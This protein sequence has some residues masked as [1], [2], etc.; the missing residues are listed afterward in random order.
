MASCSD[1]ADSGAADATVDDVWRLVTQARQGLDPAAREDSWAVAGE[2]VTLLSERDTSEIVGFAQPLSD[3]FAAS[4]QADLW[5]A[6]YVINGGASDDGFE[7]FR[8]WLITQGQAVFDQALADPDS[9]ADLPAVT[10]ACSR[11]DI[12]EEEA[13][14]YVASDAYHDATDEELPADALT[15]RYPELDFDVDFEEES[16]MRRLL[17]RLTNLCYEPAE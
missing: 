15:V 3:L 8:G 4:Y 9:L 6:A 7:Y 11:G 17:P 1:G 2:M 12:L 13:V 16:E 5:A 10:I 14:L